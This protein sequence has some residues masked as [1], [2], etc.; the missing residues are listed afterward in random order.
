MHLLPCPIRMFNLAPITTALV[1]AIAII[2]SPIVA[3]QKVDSCSFPGVTC[4]TCLGRWESGSSYSRSQGPCVW[5]GSRTTNTSDPGYIGT[6]FANNGLNKYNLCQQYALPVYEG[7]SSFVCDVVIS[8][9]EVAGIVIGVL[10]LVSAAMCYKAATAASKPR[11]PQYKWLAFGFFLPVVSVLILFCLRKRGHFDSPALVHSSQSSFPS[12]PYSSALNGSAQSAA[13]S[14]QGPAPPTAHT[15]AYGQG[16]APYLDTQILYAQ[17][18]YVY[19][20]SP[21]PAYP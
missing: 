18:G 10:S 9:P 17:Q 8:P 13:Y 3:A 11:T 15:S 21:S 19:S 5:C 1:A 12:V 16:S 6:C 7:T 2:F 14:P 20:Q 4:K